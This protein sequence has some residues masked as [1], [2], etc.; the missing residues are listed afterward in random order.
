MQ[1]RLPDSSKHLQTSLSL[2]VAGIGVKLYCEEIPFSRLLMARYSGFL[3]EGPVQLEA[4]IKFGK[5]QR[6]SNL[7]D[8]NITFQNEVL[9]LNCSGQTGFIDSRKGSAA[10]N[11]TQAH[12]LEDADYFLRLIYALLSFD[13]GGVLFHAAGILREGAAYL[14]F[15]HSGSGKTTVARLSQNDVVLNDDLV[16][17]LPSMGSAQDWFVYATPFWNPTQVK[18]NQTNG[19]LVGM[20][21][22]VQDKQVYLEEISRGLALAEIITNVPVIPEDP[23]R[24]GFLLQRGGTLLRKVPVQRLHFLPDSSFWDVI[25]AGKRVKTDKVRTS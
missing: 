12:P 17:L 8:A 9:F 6:D 7:L 10:V 13:A 24:H 20:F 22:L 11:L 25:E 2:S 23:A 21:R 16:V 15:G 18:P 14:F 1:N 19:P 3:T 5:H 4:E